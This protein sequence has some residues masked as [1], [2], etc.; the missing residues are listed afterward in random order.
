MFLSRAAILLISLCQYAIAQQQSLILTFPPPA[1]KNTKTIFTSGENVHF[2][3][4]STWPTISL[5]LWQG[6]DSGR[7]PH[8][9]LLTNV[10]NTT[11]SY[12]WS[13]HNLKGLSQDVPLHLYLYNSDNPDCQFCHS[14]SSNFFV[15][16]ASAASSSS[17][18]TSSA[19]TSSTTS[20]SA[21]TTAEVQSGSGTSTGGSNKLG[22][23][24]GLGLGIP[25][26]ILIIG[27]AGWFFLR[28][29]R[30][31]QAIAGMAAVEPLAERKEEQPHSASGTAG[32]AER[33]HHA[34][35]EADSNTVSEAYG[36]KAFVEA[37]QDREPIELEGDSAPQGPVKY[38]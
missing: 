16:N 24:L 27:L 26:A 10:T 23:G 21:S 8:Q 2:T 3:W 31:K 4:A 11:V 35:V 5:E 15:Q 1:Y 38:R 32:D 9:M 22:L 18:L 7:N 29:R 33:G 13:A 17:A 20:G 19:T 28:N 30:Q 14:N 25:L 36:G 37:P 34:P 6:P 12:V